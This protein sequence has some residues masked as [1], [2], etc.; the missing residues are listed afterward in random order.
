[1]NIAS[2]FELAASAPDEALARAV[3]DPMSSPISQIAA[4]S[5]LSSRQQL[6][7]EAA[8]MRASQQGTV[9]DKILTPAGYRDGGVVQAFQDGGLAD[10]YK[11]VAAFE[12]G[13]AGAAAKNPYSS[14][15]GKWQMIDSTR[16]YLDKKY[17][18]DPK[19]RSA[20]TED[21]RMKVYTAE[22]M[23][24]LKRAGVPQTPGALYA[25]HL[26][27]Q[28]GAVDFLQAYSADPSRR[29][30]DFFS[31]E[32]IRVNPS[33]FDSKRGGKL[34]SQTDKT[35]A[36]VMAKL[37]RVGGGTGI[38]G[39]T[40]VSAKSSE[41]SFSD[42]LSRGAQALAE[43]APDGSNPGA[44]AKFFQEIFYKEPEAVAPKPAPQP[45]YNPAAAQRDTS[46]SDAEDEEV[47]Q[48]MK[49]QQAQRMRRYREQMNQGFRD[50]GY[51]SAVEQTLR[52]MMPGFG[53]FRDGG[54]VQ[55]FRDGSE[56][57]VRRAD[58][59][60]VIP[61]R[62]PYDRFG[63][64]RP[65]GSLVFD[66]GPGGEPPGPGYDPLAYTGT[67]LG[68]P[69]MPPS[70]DP[71]TGME[72][73]GAMRDYLRRSGYQPSGDVP[74]SGPP[75]VGGAL[76]IQPGADFLSR[77]AFAPSGEIPFSGPPQPGG[78]SVRTF[79]PSGEAPFSDP[80][81]SSGRMSG[82]VPI[83]GFAPSAEQA[84]KDY[85][86]SRD[87]SLQR[88]RDIAAQKNPN[89][90]AAGALL[91]EIGR[92]GDQL[93][94]GAIP[95]GVDTLGM[96]LTGLYGTLFE[97]MRPGA[98]DDQTGDKKVPV[99][100]G[101]AAPKPPSKPAAKPSAAPKAPPIVPPGTPGGGIATGTQS[102]G[103]GVGAGGAG[104]TTP[105]STY[106]PAEQ[107]VRDLYARDQDRLA[108]MT[109]REEEARTIARINA[110]LAIAGGRS[111]YFAVNLAN[112]IP[113]LQQYQNQRDQLYSESDR[114]EREFMQRLIGAR[115]A[116]IQANLERYKSSNELEAAKARANVE[117][118]ELAQKGKITFKDAYEI[119]LK[120]LYSSDPTKP[121]PMT[122]YREA[123][124][125]ALRLASQTVTSGNEAL[126][127]I[128]NSA[129]NPIKVPGAR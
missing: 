26:L 38:T 67:L 28:R 41:G 103:G 52:T 53:G 50:G 24:A 123:E 109:A 60:L 6:R 56:G 88:I 7:Q 86:S 127:F 59:S 39:K 96:G 78:L 75:P 62:Y 25:G 120:N 116:D 61:I 19:D 31:A 3:R 94:T 83:E 8:G 45:L 43:R 29:A 76:A 42:F 10:Y 54:I 40:A 36:D 73:F 91:Y 48:Q 82:G 87:Q 13:S 80:L 11:R 129:S 105:V 110:G 77:N 93:L 58:G 104:A 4:L 114:F 37:D 106:G 100:R 126:T 5:E 101:G 34:T 18:F 79:Q 16:D 27:G 117:L 84:Y 90:G 74:F 113:V 122:D 69:D 55:A 92:F 70:P 9:A 111:P 124:K 49:E 68:Q 71:M 115:G 22:T 1:M 99:E 12:S 112:A 98:W 118:A 125:E 23:D 81:T 63:T 72:A 128:N 95:A 33:I 121:G 44:I 47:L 21:K 64:V 14:A 46:M 32:V 2:D 20:A 119:H 65:D 17:G 30:Q 107:F 51:V 15:S 85:R 66:V 35:L 108:R 89:R 102:S 97:E 57:A